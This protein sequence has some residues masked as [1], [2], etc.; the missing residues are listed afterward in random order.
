MPILGQAAP[1]ANA[2]TDVYTVPQKTL[3]T[4][5]VLI[6]NRGAGT[7]GYRVAVRPLGAAIANQHYIAFDV[8]LAANGKDNTTPF[9]VGETDIVTVRATDANVSFTV[10]GVEEPER[11]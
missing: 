11:E 3:A 9:E 10:T 1:L 2:D 4:V 8:A 7:P 6:A 5:R